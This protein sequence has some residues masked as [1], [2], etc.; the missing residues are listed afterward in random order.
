MA[1]AADADRPFAG[2]SWIASPKSRS[3]SMFRML[4]LYRC[5]GWAAENGR[6]VT[7]GIRSMAAR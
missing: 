4:S 3:G 6:K 1:A 7:P 2:T 5:A